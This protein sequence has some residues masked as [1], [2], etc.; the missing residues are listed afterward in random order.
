MIITGTI[1]N[2]DQ[3]TPLDQNGNTYQNI[4]IQDNEG[5]EYTGRIGSKNGYTVNTP[6][7]VT[8]EMK[9]GNRGEYM[10]FH[11]YNPQ[12]QYPQGDGQQRPPQQRQQAT[13]QQQ[14][15]QQQGPT[16]KDILIIR[17]C[18]IKAAA[19]LAV[20]E[21][22][23]TILYAR[24]FENYVLGRSQEAQPSTQ[25]SGSN[26]DYDPNYQQPEDQIPF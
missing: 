19:Q 18:C 8:F 14:A 3:G 21:P 15:P 1:T 7:Q 9:Q 13:R 20:N 23:E 22:E 26:P 2:A 4:V 17:Q 25:P 10:Y 12:S 6:I 24:K 16:P 5:R 11:K